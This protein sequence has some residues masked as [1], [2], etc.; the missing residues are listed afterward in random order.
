MTAAPATTRYLRMSVPV[1]PWTTV[2]EGHPAPRQRCS[3]S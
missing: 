2:T 3:G 1:P